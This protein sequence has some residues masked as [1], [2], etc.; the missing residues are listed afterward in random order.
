MPRWAITAAAGSLDD[1][2]VSGRECHFG[3]STKLLHVAGRPDQIISPRF[4]VP[5]AAIDLEVPPVSTGGI[6]F[7]D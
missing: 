6:Q 1:E 4:A 2:T 7:T 5:A 3:G